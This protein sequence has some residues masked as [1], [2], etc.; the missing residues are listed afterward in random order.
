MAR[1]PTVATLPTMARAGDGRTTLVEIKAVDD[2]Y[3]L[4]GTVTTEPAMPLAALLARRGDAFGAAADPA[5]LTRLDLKLG[6]RITIGKATIELRATLTERA[7]Q[8]RRRH[9]LRAAPA[10]SAQAALRASGAVAARQSGAL[11]IPAAP[12]AGRTSSDSAVAGLE[13]AG[14]DRIPE[15]RLGHPHAQARPRR[16]SNAMSSASAN[17]SRSSP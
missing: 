3:P 9:R 12:A 17:S 5:L 16:S 15:C 1:C 8:A 11:A 7:G 4:F 2:A 13:T 6:D 10:R 14:P